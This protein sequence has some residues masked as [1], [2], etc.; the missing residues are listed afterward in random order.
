MKGYIT[1]NYKMM[2]LTAGLALGLTNS[3]F[4]LK[5]GE[6]EA[7]EADGTYAMNPACPACQEMKSACQPCKE[8]V[9]VHKKKHHKKAKKMECVAPAKMEEKKA[10]DMKKDDMKK[11]EVK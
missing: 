2:M 3:A 4:A 11:E 6:P 1:M 10:D 8:K 9:K 7:H 5:G